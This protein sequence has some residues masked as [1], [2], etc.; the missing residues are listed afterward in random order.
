MGPTHLG[1]TKNRVGLTLTRID[2]LV[3]TL[4]L[5]VLTLHLGEKPLATFTAAALSGRAR[6]QDKSIMP[7]NP[8]I[9]LVCA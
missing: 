5:Q 7:S 9:R 3:K 2:A 4:Q 6:N 8:F 1:H